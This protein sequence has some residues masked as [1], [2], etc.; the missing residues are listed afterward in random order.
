M[1]MRFLGCGGAGGVPSLSAGWGAC[2]PTNPKNRRTRCGAL[3]EK[4]ETRLLI[5]TPP[6]LRFQL[7]EAG[8]NRLDAVFYTHDH[9]DHLHGI[10]DLREVNRAMKK[11][12]MVYGAADVLKGARQRFGY[13][14]QNEE[15][16]FGAESLY[17]PM[18]VPRPLTGG[19]LTVGGIAVVHFDQDHGYSRSTGYRFDDM[20][21]TTDV[22]RLSEEA[23][24]LLEG[25]KVWVIG[26]LAD[27]PHPTHAHIGLA[28]EWIERIKPERAYITHMGPRLDYEAVRAMLPAHVAPA[29]DGLEIEL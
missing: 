21:Y 28:L 29:Y 20:A 5:D 1:K 14:F 9:A 10:D 7:L 23:F 8:V 22:I 17:R 24:A 13:A 11:S 16:L 27:T 15:D 3:I 2:D 19:P 12:L 18:L 25:V 26:C 4:D 6:D